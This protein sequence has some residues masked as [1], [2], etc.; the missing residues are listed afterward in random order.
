MSSPDNADAD[1]LEERALELAIEET[2][3]ESGRWFRLSIRIGSIILIMGSGTVKPEGCFRDAACELGECPKVGIIQHK[4]DVMQVMNHYFENG[5][6][7]FTQRINESISLECSNGEVAPFVGHNVFLRW[8]SI[9]A[10]FALSLMNYL[11]FGWSAEVD[12][13]YL[14]LFEVWLAC[15]AVFPILGNLGFMLLEY[16]LGQMRTSDL[17]VEFR[18]LI[19][20]RYSIFELT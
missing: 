18:D 5:I 11:L 20:S 16:R 6:A 1:Q 17:V 3:K 8:N 9:A 15:M 2:Y 4:S 7:H 12:G 14:H 19:S 10:G 13:Y